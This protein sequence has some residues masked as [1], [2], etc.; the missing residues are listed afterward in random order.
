MSSRFYNLFPLFIVFLRPN[1]ACT[2]FSTLFKFSSFFCFYFIFIIPI[3]IIRSFPYL[4]CCFLLLRAFS[5]FQ[6]LTFNF[7]TFFLYLYIFYFVLTSYP[8][9][10]YALLNIFLLLLFVLYELFFSYLIYCSMFLIF[11]LFFPFHSVNVIPL[12]VLTY[13]SQC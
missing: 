3:H 4:V 5:H 2:L 9:Y 6:R 1:H 10:S 11:S 8:R 13:S 7:F 12:I